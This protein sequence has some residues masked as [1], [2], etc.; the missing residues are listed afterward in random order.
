MSNWAKNQQ[1]QGLPLTDDIIR[2]KARVFAATVGNQECHLK[3]QSET[4][5]EKFKQKNSLFDTKPR[6]GTDP[7]DSDGNHRLA[8]K[9]GYET[10]KEIS[11]I[12][13][14]SALSG[15]PN[16]GQ[17]NAK[18]FMSD[19]YVDFTGSCRHSHSQSSASLPSP[20]SD[21]T[22]LS[23][24]SSEVRSPT[25][26]FF[27]PNSSCRPSP[28][29]LP[30]QQH[31]LANLANATSLRPR[32]GTFPTINSDP[33]YTTSLHPAEPSASKYTQQSIVAPTLESP[34]EE[35]EEPAL[36]IESTLQQP[37]HQPLQPSPM[38]C[39]TMNNS[40]GSM[41]PPPTRS[42]NASPLIGSSSAA[43][44]PSQDEARRAL[45]VLISF[46]RSQPGIDPQEY[47]TMGKLMEKLKLKGD[48]LQ[49]ETH[50]IGTGDRGD[51]SL[52]IIKKRSIHS[53]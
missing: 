50:S 44:P 36:K 35:I 26:P 14:S 31:Q 46:L 15:S 37:H 19:D 42:M 13:P 1:R 47:F 11:P 48:G 45:E 4:W 5:L 49:S 38:S 52:P 39:Q 25:S 9:S 17:E 16:Q 29:V 30:S 24:F 18:D 12:S 32:R 10:P 8:S 43:A 22:V 40:P 41:P 23:T 3:V 53:V 51:G 7:N 21:N 6:K 34:L 28:S 27:S 2:D 33:A 20:Y